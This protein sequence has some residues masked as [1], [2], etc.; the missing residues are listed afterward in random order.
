M[1]ALL[2]EPVDDPDLH[3]WYAR[4]W[5]DS[6]GLRMNFVTS[7]DGAVT[8]DGLSEGLQT[9]GDN[10]VFAALR[11]LADVV[12]VGSRTVLLEGYSR[13]APKGA[14]LELRRKHAMPDALQL[15]VVSRS[16][17]GLRPDL[18]L[19]AE[20]DAPPAIVVTTGRAE[21]DGLEDVAEVIVAG[22]DDVDFRRVRDEL[23]ARGLPRVL[24]E[25]GPT[26]FGA[27]AGAVDELCLSVS[28]ILVG[29]GPGRITAGLP[30][31]DGPR[32][33]ELTGLLEDGSALFLRLR[34]R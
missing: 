34:A 28:P 23:A 9:R 1:R 6:G 33:F 20:G 13:P 5:L 32:R 12:L 4:D 25:G 3:A 11:D 14:R 26:L 27:A 16:G 31:L 22:E 15:A 18:P 7:L 17:S 29:P 24:S 2:P 10:R 8:V 21:L 30:W 19:F